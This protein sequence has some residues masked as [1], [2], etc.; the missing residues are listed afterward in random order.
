[1]EG[2]A[3]AGDRPVERKPG[4]T[5]AKNKMSKDGRLLKAG[6]EA[7]T[8]FDFQ[9][10]GMKLVRITERIEG[11]KSQSG[12]CYRVAPPLR[13]GDAATLYDADWFDP[14]PMNIL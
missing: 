2:S 1:M 11:T 3:Q 7:L 14:A 12:I 9:G 8:D 4:I 13:G 5:S 10:R 6:D